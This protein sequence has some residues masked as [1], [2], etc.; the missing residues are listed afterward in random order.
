MSVVIHDGP[1]RRTWAP[2]RASSAALKVWLGGGA[3][4]WQD[5]ARTS[6]ALADGDPVAALGD[7]SGSGN[8]FLQ[9]TASKR[10]TLKLG[11]TPT[12][13][14]VVRFDGVDD[15]MQPAA[16]FILGWP[17]GH[18]LARLWVASDPASA[19]S[20]H[21]IW[22]FCATAAEFTTYPWNDGVVYSAFLA[23][24]ADVA[25]PGPS[26]VAWRT[27]EEIRAG[28]QSSA[29]LD[30]ATLIAPW[31]STAGA[32]L[33]P[34]LGGDGVAGGGGVQADLDLAEL[35]IYDGPLSAA[36]AAAARAYLAY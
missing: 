12:G 24:A 17:E 22:R 9:A 8:H 36:E 10:P 2:W 25:D 29:L 28:G 5:T 26:L 33:L 1:R 18:L 30:G 21:G 14:P 32:N 6:P 23:T 16:N 15:F 34:T 13:R 19:A 3:E 11:V 4:L 31:A 20:K 35:L 7:R 27:F